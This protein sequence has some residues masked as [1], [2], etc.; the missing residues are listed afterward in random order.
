[1]G[2]II[3]VVALIF[4]VPNVIDAIKKA[5]RNEKLAREREEQ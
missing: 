4:I 5:E 1:M 2:F 3:F